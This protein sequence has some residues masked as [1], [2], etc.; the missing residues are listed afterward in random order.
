MVHGF[1]VQTNTWT[2]SPTG[3]NV[4]SHR[5]PQGESQVFEFTF[6]PTNDL[7]GMSAIYF[8]RHST[9][10][11]WWGV[12][13]SVSSATV[14]IP[15]GNSND[16]G[17]SKYEGW[18]RVLDGSYPA[19][20][21]KL[22][23]SMISTPGFSPDLATNVPSGGTNM[24]V[25]VNDA[26]YLG[27]ITNATLT[28]STSNGVSVA[29]RTIYLTVNTNYLT[30]GGSQT[31]WESNIDGGGYDLTNVGAIAA[32]AVTGDGSGLSGVV[33]GEVDSVVGAV[34]GLVKADGGGNISAAVE[35]TDYQGVLAEGAFADGD[36]TKLD[37]IE[38]LADV[39]DATNVAAAGAGMTNAYNTW[40]TSNL[41]EGDMY[42]GIAGYL[43]ITALSFSA[44]IKE[45]TSKQ[46]V[47]GWSDSSRQLYN[48]AGENILN[49]PVSGAPVLKDAASTDMW[50]VEGTA[51]GGNQIVSYTVAT[52][53]IATLGASA[54]LADVLAE[55]NDAN[56]L[57][58]TNANDGSYTGVLATVDYVDAAEATPY[59]I[60]YAA[61][62]TVSVANG[63]LQAYAPTNTTTI[64]IEDGDTN[65]V[66]QVNLSLYAG[67]NSVTLGTNN[68]TFASAIT[69]STNATTT[70]LYYSAWKSTEWEGAEL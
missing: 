67:T 65:N 62:V 22:N 26:V 37:G 70:I 8:Y 46:S 31:P 57:S 32:S 6:S 23:L 51:T 16:A 68:V 69:P 13:G 38:P 59:E 61:T 42:F 4:I 47:F 58:I 9:M 52:N 15:W 55:G 10:T 1:P 56:G 5:I 14:T 54:T 25:Y 28:E 34:T 35:D 21:I 19:Y 60:T 2:V 39:T 12:T 66:G 18:V 44:T 50:T 20:R 27:A 3:P 41:W 29:D 45:Y 64:L 11:N 43:D 30:S 33:T 36:K 40:A 53:L 63:W 7:S 48:G 49:I 24:G 17:Y